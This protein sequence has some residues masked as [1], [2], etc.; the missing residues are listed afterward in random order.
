MERN[1]EIVG[2]DRKQLKAKARQAMSAARPAPFWVA[3]ALMAIMLVLNVLAMSLD[4][5]LDALRTMYAAALQGQLVYAE[6][7]AAG[8]LIGWLLGLAIQVMSI[9]LTVGFIIYALRVWR[10]EKAGVGDLFDSFGIF[11]RAIWIQVLPSLLVSIWSLLYVMPV[12]TMVVMTGD[13]WWLAAGLPLIVPALM[14]VYSYRLAP[15]LMLDN[16]GAGCWQCVILSRQIMRGHRWEAFVLDMSFL[17]WAL[18][19]LI[20]VVGFILMIWLSAYIQITGAGF[21]EKLAG[22]F[23]AEHAPFP[24]QEPPAV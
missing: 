11:F 14:A 9:E 16:P 20:P 22:A 10:G 13:T 3:L 6:P 19:C 17:G 24:G 8:G 23:M 12:T 7:R 15:Y 2:M 21:Y 18:L 5:T 1:R 4:G